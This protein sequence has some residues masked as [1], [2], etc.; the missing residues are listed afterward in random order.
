[1]GGQAARN[2]SESAELKSKGLKRPLLETL[3]ATEGPGISDINKSNSYNR[4]N[5][6]IV[7]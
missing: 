7:S 2:F 4:V 1:M 5:E 6:A 3:L